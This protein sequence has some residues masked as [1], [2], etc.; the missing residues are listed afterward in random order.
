MVTL[1]ALEL[2]AIIIQVFQKEKFEEG[3]IGSSLMLMLYYAFVIEIDS[4]YDQLANVFSRT[5]YNTYIE[6]INAKGA[7]T[8]LMFDVNGL[9]QAMNRVDEKMYECKQQYYQQVGNDRRK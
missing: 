1:F 2:F 5:Y 3:Y 9:K 8:L 7:Y 6:R 4:K